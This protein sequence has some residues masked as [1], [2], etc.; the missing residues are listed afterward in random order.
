MTRIDGPGGTREPE[1]PKENEAK[2][3]K[4]P[5]ELILQ[6]AAEKSAKPA[7]KSTT[8]AAFND[9]AADVAPASDEASVAEKFEQAGSEASLLAQEAPNQGATAEGQDAERARD[10]RGERGDRGDRHD[11]GSSHDDDA[12][13]GQQRSPE[14]EPVRDR[15]TP[16]ADRPF[17]APSADF[18]SSLKGGLAS[19]I[20]PHVLHQMVESVRLGR[21]QD[22]AKEIRLDLRAQD[23]FDGMSVRVLSREGKITATFMV[24]QLA[25]RDALQATLPDMIKRLEAQGLQVVDVRVELRGDSMGQGAGSDREGRRS[26]QDSGAPDGGG[27]GEGPREKKPQDGPS[28][29]SGTEYTL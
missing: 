4:T 26:G 9:A 6:R 7:A 17:Q 24:D 14:S 23:G 15:V 21:T 8:D 1:R 16:A 20:P 29:D 12:E 18:G 19:R 2:K 28:S 3:P 11:Q 13:P 27:T 10:E 5:F 25:Q 22:G